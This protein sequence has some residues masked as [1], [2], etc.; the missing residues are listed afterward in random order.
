MRWRLL[1]AALS[2][3]GCRSRPETTSAPTPMAESGLRECVVLVHGLGRTE[4]SL[5]S[6]GDRLEDEGYATVRYRYHSTRASIE[7]HAAELA[8]RL[9]ELVPAGTSRVHFVTHSLGGIV[10]RQ[11]LSERA[12]RLPAPLGSVVM[13]APPNQGSEL[14]D[15]LRDAGLLRPLLGPAAAELGTREEDVPRR[16]G[17]V[18]FPCGVITGDLSLNPLNPWLFDGP[19][20]GK[21]AVDRAKVEGMADF[22]VVHH[23]HSFL[24]NA[25]DVQVQVVRFL[26]TGRFDHGLPT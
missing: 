2:L 8:R 19:S 1:L 20:D 26:R 16:L 5:D 21:V 11:L 15:A 24:M 18:A 14:A 25:D 9:D 4:R 23:G 22:L 12:L 17:P 10:V 7:E 3:V 13:L 6:L